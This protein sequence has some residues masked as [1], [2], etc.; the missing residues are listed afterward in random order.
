MKAYWYNLGANW[1]HQFQEVAYLQQAL[2]HRS[3]GAVNY[4]RL[5]FLGDALLEAIIS[6][7]LYR[8]RPNVPEGDLTRLRAKIV[9]GE[10]L[11]KIANHLGLGQYIRLGAGERKSGGHRRASILADCVE[12]LIG[13]VYLDSDFITCERY[14]LK[15]FAEDLQ[16]LPDKALEKLKDPKTQLQEWLQER[17]LPLPV[18]T[19]ISE[20]GPPHDRTFEVIGQSEDY[21]ARATA[22]TRKSAEQQ[23]AEALLKHY[24]DLEKQKHKD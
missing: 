24:L 8:H 11:A 13:A 19:I 20:T 9:N 14:V 23:V 2:T 21:Q 6:S 17:N 5:E 1:G 15:L 22:T 18:Y 10:N 3:F 12:A 4:E 16:E 7:Y